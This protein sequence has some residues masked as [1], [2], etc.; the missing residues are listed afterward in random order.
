MVHIVV[1]GITPFYLP[2]KF[3]EKNWQ[4]SLGEK[5]W[6]D[7]YREP[8]PGHFHAECPSG[9]E[10]CKVHY[11]PINPHASPVDALLHFVESDLGGAITVGVAVGVIVYLI[12]SRK[13][14]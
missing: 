3:V 9:S 12:L 7:H 8:P 2:R 13:G 4:W 14:N 11:D 10:I 6:L 5:F 1:D